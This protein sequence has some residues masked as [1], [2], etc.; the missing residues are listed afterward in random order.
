MKLNQRWEIPGRPLPIYF[1]PEHQRY[2]A[3]SAFWFCG[4]C[5]KRYAEVRS[6][7]DDRPAIWRAVTGCCP[8]CRGSKWSIPGSLENLTIVGW[9]LVPEEVIRYQLNCELSYLSS[10]DHPHNQKDF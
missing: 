3:W 8:D 6:W 5:G 1:T 10:P 4:E 7:I 9:N 2:C